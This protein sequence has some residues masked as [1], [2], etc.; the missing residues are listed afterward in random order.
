MEPPLVVYRGAEHKAEEDMRN[1]INHLRRS[2]ARKA[3]PQFDGYNAMT[4]EIMLLLFANPYHHD[5]PTTEI[6]SDKQ[7]IAR[8][9]LYSLCVLIR[10]FRFTPNCWQIA[11]GV[12]LDKQNGKK[13]TLRRRII[14]ILHPAGK[15]HRKAILEDKGEK[16]RPISHVVSSCIE[17]GSK[18]YFLKECYNGDTK[19]RREVGGWTYM[20]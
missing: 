20:M 18:R 7:N 13:K 2:K 8:R 1:M 11:K 15:A 17:E 6:I 16:K 3:V 14:N 10:R 19:K 4:R 12:S 9:A 5:R